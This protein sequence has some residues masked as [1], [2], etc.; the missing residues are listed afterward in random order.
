LALQGDAVRTTVENA[1]KRAGLTPRVEYEAQSTGVMLKLV[2][3]GLAT[4]VL[5]L[6]MAADRART[7][8]L[9]MRPI[10]SPELRRHLR[11]RQSAGAD[12]RSVH[13]EIRHIVEQVLRA[14]ADDPVLRHA[15]SFTQTPLLDDAL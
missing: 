2:E 10:V 12:N 7:G 3:D 8:V 4:T 15:Y 6:A 9:A 11:W 13:V 14:A 5:P 1:A